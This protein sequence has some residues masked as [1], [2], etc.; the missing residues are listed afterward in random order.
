MV[1]GTLLPWH[2]ILYD[3][4]FVL[5]SNWPI[6][7]PEH[8]E[9]SGVD[10]RGGGQ[11]GHHAPGIAVLQP[12]E[13]AIELGAGGEVELAFE[14]HDVVARCRGVSLDPI[15]VRNRARVAASVA[16]KPVHLSP[17]WSE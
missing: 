13:L 2:E 17:P 10:E 4:E 9:R 3:V 15:R 6:L 16:P 5:R 8:A 12:L 7:R 1:Q 14:R 11:V